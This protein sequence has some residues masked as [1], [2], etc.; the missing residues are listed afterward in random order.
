MLNIRFLLLLAAVCCAHALAHD[1]ARG[2]RFDSAGVIDLSARPLKLGGARSIA[3]APLNESAA[4][5]ILAA[6]ALTEDDAALPFSEAAFGCKEDAAD[7]ARA[8]ERTRIDANRR[9]VARDGKQLVITPIEGSVANL[10]D[11]SQPET[12]QADGDSETHWYLG[13]LAGSGYHRVEVQFGHDAP[14]SFLI[15]PKSGKVAFVHNGGDVT[16]ISQSGWHIAD[17]GSSGE[18]RVAALDENG[19]RVELQ[20]APAKPEGKLDVKLKGWHNP[21][22]LDLEVDVPAHA[23]QPA[24]RFAVRLTRDAGGS[25][26]MAGSDAARIAA[27]DWR[28]E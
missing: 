4:S 22:A 17:L 14:G 19:P 15:D 20:C 13:R 25:W 12:K 26:S 24:A 6:P 10:I 23:T 2:L 7:C 16:A 3:T 28:C 27:L 5:A 11:W 8:G 9:R 18:L 21:F 1:A